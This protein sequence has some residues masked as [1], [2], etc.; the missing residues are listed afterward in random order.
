MFTLKIKTSG[1]REKRYY[2]YIENPLILRCV[3]SQRHCFLHRHWLSISQESSTSAKADLESHRSNL[4]TS[5]ILNHHHSPVK[6][7]WRR[8]HSNLLNYQ[9]RRACG[10]IYFSVMGHTG[11]IGRSKWTIQVTWMN[12][13]IIKSC[14]IP[15]QGGKEQFSG[16]SADL[17]LSF[18]LLFTYICNGKILQTYCAEVWNYLWHL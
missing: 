14:C 7:F 10:T 6:G 1:L 18:R 3:K 16:K 17:F 13:A 5:F 15:R 8:S 4:L 12:R 9:P 2:W 11:Q